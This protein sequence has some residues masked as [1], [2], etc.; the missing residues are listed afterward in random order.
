MDQ[1]VYNINSAY[2]T[3]NHPSTHKVPMVYNGWLFVFVCRIDY[4]T[5]IDP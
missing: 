1:R 5:P 2:K 4:Y 3:N